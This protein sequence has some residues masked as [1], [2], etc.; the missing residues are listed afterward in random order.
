MA[1]QCA[2]RSYV[3]FVLAMVMF[4]VLMGLSLQVINS[5]Q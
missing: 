1:K 3:L 2:S 4:S 5:V